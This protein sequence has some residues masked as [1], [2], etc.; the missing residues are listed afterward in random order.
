MAQSIPFGSRSTADQVLAGIDLSRKRVL[1]TGCDSAI[2]LETMKAL[3]ANGAVVIGVARTL[4]DAYAACSAVARSTPLGCDPSDPA[5][6]DAAVESLQRLSGPLD[7]LI[8]NSLALQ[9]FADHIAQFVLVNRLAEFVRHGTGRIVIATNDRNMAELPVESVVFD[10][11]RDERLYDARAFHEQTKLAAALFVEELSRR[12]EARGIL[13]NAFHS[14][15]TANQTRHT[16]RSAAQR[17]IQSFVGYFRK[18]PAQRAATPALLAASPLVV[19][20]TGEYWLDCQISHQSS[21]IRDAGLA[22]RLWDISAQIAAVMFGRINSPRAARP[23]GDSLFTNVARFHAQ[24][25]EIGAS[26]RDEYRLAK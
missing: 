3:S 19:G 20:I 9:C 11:L 21:L 25:L 22:R 16:A 10:D 18:S 17:L 6:V 7:A 8:I 5:S 13:V 2:G 23:G 12:L 14:G 1:V 26:R 15:T 4:G 24:T